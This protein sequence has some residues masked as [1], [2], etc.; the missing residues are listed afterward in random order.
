MGGSHIIKL[1]KAH[2][3]DCEAFWTAPPPR[4]EALARLETL[5]RGV[6]LGDIRELIAIPP[7]T[8]QLLREYAAEHPEE[9][10]KISRTIELR[11]VVGEEF[12]RLIGRHNSTQ[13]L[14]TLSE[15]S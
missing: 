1:A 11:R 9:R 7:E 13:T 8:E 2:V 10:G 4:I 5:S 6:T 12:E 3:S 15:G 14:V